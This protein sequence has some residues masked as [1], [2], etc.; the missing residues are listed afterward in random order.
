MSNET[1]EKAPKQ[2]KEATKAP[3]VERKGKAEITRKANGL[4]IVNYK[5]E[6]K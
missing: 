3:A 2:T 1:T 5:P 6:D 4:V